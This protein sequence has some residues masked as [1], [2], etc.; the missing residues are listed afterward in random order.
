M[1]TY[2]EG[3]IQMVSRKVFKDRE[4]G[5]ERV[6]YKNYV[7]TDEGEIFEVNSKEDFSKYKSQAGVLT[8]T[9]YSQRDSSGFWLSLTKFTPQDLS[10][11]P[12]EDSH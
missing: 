3:S 5:E 10:V 6:T 11:E 4:T 1:H 12:L 2:L 9:I 7:E 8:L